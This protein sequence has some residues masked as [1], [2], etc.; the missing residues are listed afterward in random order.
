MVQGEAPVESKI[1]STSEPNVSASE[2]N[3]QNAHLHQQPTGMHSETHSTI[4][5]PSTMDVY[6][7]SNSNSNNSYS[8]A[9]QVNAWSRSR[10]P[11]A[12]DE[13]S[14]TTTPSRKLPASEGEDEAA[15]S[16]SKR[17]RVDLSLSEQS[18]GASP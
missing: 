10:E 14:Q 5:T 11:F 7:N 9:N 3:H 8:V 4:A 6:I 18:P 1:A 15:G 16:T 17:I 13:T 12:V 2:A